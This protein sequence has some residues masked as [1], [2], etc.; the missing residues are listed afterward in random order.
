MKVHELSGG[1][2][3]LWADTA[4]VMLKVRQP[5][6]DPVELAQHEVEELIEVLQDLLKAVS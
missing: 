4:S 1:E 2:I 5:Y 3:S 6:G